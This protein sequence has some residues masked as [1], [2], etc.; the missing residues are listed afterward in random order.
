MKQRGAV[1]IALLTACGVNL[2]LRDDVIYT[3]DTTADCPL[4]LTCATLAHECVA[5]LDVTPP[6]LTTITATDRDSVVLVFDEAL[7]IALASQ[8]SSF[9]ITRD[10]GEPLTVQAAGAVGDAKSVV[11]RTGRQRGSAVYAVT[12]QV[13]D[14]QG[15]PAVLEVSTFNG[16]GPPPDAEPP[17]ITAPT[18]A[19]VIVVPENQ[20]AAPEV[21]LAW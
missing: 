5:T 7:D 17:S 18:N 14:D 9:T 19:S 8:P 10:D 21:T 1:L 15:N 12:T 13:A 4:K 11:L 16:F 20:R 3:C 2:E 6:R